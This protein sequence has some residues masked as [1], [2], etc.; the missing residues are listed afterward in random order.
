LPFGHLRS[1]DRTF[2]SHTL[3]NSLVGIDGQLIYLC[4]DKVMFPYVNKFGYWENGLSKFISTHLNNSDE[5]SIFLDIGANQG[6]VTLQVINGCNDLTKIDFI[7]I[8]PVLKF[9][10]NLQKNFRSSNSIASY[11]LLN[12]GLGRVSNPRA[13]TYTSKSNST[14]TQ[15]LDLILDPN[16][17]LSINKIVI[18]SVSQFIVSYLGTK[19]YSR[20]VVK[21]DTD[22]DDL[23]IFDCFVNSTVRAKI[24]LYILEVVTTAILKADLDIFVKNCCSF[25]NWLLILRNGEEL[26]DKQKIRNILESERNYVGDLYLSS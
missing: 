18:V 23:E 14:S 19:T 10:T 22:G 11:E 21:S 13:Y 1:Y 3:S 8:E 17:K 9:F 7:L 5:K 2:G 25:N 12:F 6:L 15:H 16:N 26:K 4:H 24:S 20:L